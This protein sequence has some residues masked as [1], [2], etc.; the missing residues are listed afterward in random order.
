V[1]T[2]RTSTRVVEDPDHDASETFTITAELPLGTYRGAAQDG[3]V[4][5]IPSVSRLYSA[6]LCAAGF[7]PR[8][9]SEGDRLV[10]CPADEAALR[11]LEENPPDA[12]S[13]P[14]MKVNVGNVIAYR[15]DGTLKVTKESTKINKYPKHPDMSVAVA[16]SFS[17]T[18]SQMPPPQVVAVLEA[19]AADVPYLGTTET[20]V[21]LT[22]YRSTGIE[23]THV[24]DAKAS[25][26]GSGGEDIAVPL[27]GRLD[28]L[29][30]AHEEVTGRPPSKAKDRTRAD[31]RSSSFRP[32]RTRVADARYVA[33][34]AAAGDAPWSHVTVIPLD[35]EIPAPDRVA[36]AVAVHK[37]LISIIAAGEG[38]APPLVT[39]IYPQGPRPANRLGIQFLDRTMHLDHRVVLPPDTPAAL[40]LFIPENSASTDLAALARAIEDLRWLRGPGGQLRQITGEPLTVPG[41]QLWKPRPVGT[42]RLWRTAVPAMPDVRG[43]RS[44][45]W[46]FAQAALLSLGFVWRDRLPRVPGRGDAR[47]QAI[48]D[49]V[50]AQGAVVVRTAPLRTNDVHRYAH[51][52]NDHAVVRP[53]DVDMWL[54]SLAGEQTALAIGQTRHLG[55]GLLVPHDL[56]EGQV[57]AVPRHTPTE[58]RD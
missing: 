5:R 50:N 9:V 13:L 58:A 16:G 6:L 1:T 55:G 8:A 34:E 17:W 26:F 21:R 35:R 46:T 25:F 15:D 57:I 40:A 28:E 37:A 45:P 18:W 31:E 42:V 54:G 32:P 53:Y 41:T 3:R 12:V 56:P 24:L 23:A 20:P 47:Y 10:P 49:A 11:W 51:K 7:G 27:P 38:S 22:T 30:A 36:W 44:G 14:A 33:S 39:G 4:E 29:I 52:V 2:T 48:V 19:L 43:I